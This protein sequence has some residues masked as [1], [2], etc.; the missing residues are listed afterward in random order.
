MLVSFL[1]YITQDLVTE[2]DEGANMIHQT[3]ESGERLF[4][5]TASEGRDIIRQ[6]LRYC[7]HLYSSFS[8]ICCD[9]LRIGCRHTCLSSV[10]LVL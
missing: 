6:E 9:G 7:P 3:V 2:K 1:F 5:N 8:I 4:P 10:E